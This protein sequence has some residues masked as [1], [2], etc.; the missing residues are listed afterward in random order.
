[1]KTSPFRSPL[2]IVLAAFFLTACAAPESTE[3]PPSPAE[4]VVDSKLITSDL[5]RTI[6]DLLERARIAGVSACLIQNQAITW[7]GAFGLTDASAGHDVTSGT[8]FQAASL[9]KPVFAYAALQLVDQG[10]IDLDV[11]L[12]DYIGEANAR[13][14]HLGSGF[15]DP[16]VREITSRMVLTHTSGFPNWRRNGE[17]ELLFDPGERF[18][19]SGEGIGLL[20]KVVERML[21]VGLEDLM[22]TTVFESLGMENSTYTPTNVDL[23]NYAWPHDGAGKP[24]P[25]PPDLKR[26]HLAPKPHA[27]ATLF[28]TAPD[29]ARFLIAVMTGEG[30]EQTTYSEYLRPHSEVDESGTVFW[31]L[32]IG[33]EKSAAGTRAWHWGD[34]GDSM[35]FFVADP[36]TGNG[37]VYFA[38]STNGLSI[39]GDLLRIALPGDHPLLAGA[40][41]DTYAQHDSPEFR[42]AAAVYEG[43][44]ENAIALVRQLQLEGSPTPVSEAMVNRLGYWLLG[45]KRIDEAITIFELNVELYPEAWNVYDSLGE[46]QLQK[47]HRE[48]GLA[49]YRRSLELNPDNQGARQVLSEAG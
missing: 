13:A 47:G 22:R 26:R 41:L 44:A 3:A 36:K 5:E 7:C 23:E 31:G 19:Y 25:H 42:F 21:G 1:M 39:V 11:P 30:L 37:L 49:N 29:Y 43:G 28:T 14:D 9:S 38:N 24:V 10:I 48:E 45:R 34:N 33:L 27:A 6:P 15:D 16:R 40:L 20:Q 35:A 12:V 32:G 2:S 4:S 8:V 17:L 46:A 18:G